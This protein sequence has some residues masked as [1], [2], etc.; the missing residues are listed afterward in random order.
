MTPLPPGTCPPDPT[1]ARRSSHL[2]AILD[3]VSQSPETP[4]LN[5]GGRLASPLGA[6][7]EGRFAVAWS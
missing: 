6:A 4:L 7:G 3:L 5:Q 1:P 2:D